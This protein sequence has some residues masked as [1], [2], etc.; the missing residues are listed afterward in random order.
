MLDAAGV[1]F[2][3]AAVLSCRFAMLL[4]PTSA[5]GIPGTLSASFRLG[6]PDHI[7]TAGSYVA[8]LDA[9]SP[10]IL[11]NRVFVSTRMEALQWSLGRS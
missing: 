11:V 3:R 9:D 5:F 7:L 6:S 1:V 8:G 2:F 4:C 10:A